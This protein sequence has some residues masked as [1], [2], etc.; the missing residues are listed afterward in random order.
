MLLGA[1][2]KAIENYEVNRFL[3]TETQLVHKK[4]DK[5]LQMIEIYNSET[6]LWIQN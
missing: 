4:I 2:S 6:K 3:Y 1:C 5:L